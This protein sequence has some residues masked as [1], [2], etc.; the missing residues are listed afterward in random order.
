MK[1]NKKY[2]HDNKKYDHEKRICMYLGVYLALIVVFTALSFLYN[3]GFIRINKPTSHYRDEVNLDE[4]LDDILLLKEESF[5]QL[6]DERKIEVLQALIYVENSKAGIK[7]CPTIKVSDNLA[8]SIAGCY[9][10]KKCE[11]LINDDVFHSSSSRTLTSIVLHEFYHH[12]SNEL[13]DA[14]RSLPARYKDMEAFCIY[15]EFA[16]ELENYVSYEED[17]HAYYY[18]SLESS[19]RRFSEAQ[20]EGYFEYIYNY[21]LD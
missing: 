12:L 1:T 20:T 14:Y 15:R 7:T 17:Q 5:S 6:D 4:Y 11:I 8:D 3:A 9:D 10:H 18:S 13:A 19:A 21:E 2:K 16:Y